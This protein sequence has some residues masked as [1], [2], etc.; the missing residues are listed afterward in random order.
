MAKK[1]PKKHLMK[2]TKDRVLA[3]KNPHTKIPDIEICMENFIPESPSYVPCKH[4]KGKG[5]KVIN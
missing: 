4:K 1:E 2:T 5:S 3:E